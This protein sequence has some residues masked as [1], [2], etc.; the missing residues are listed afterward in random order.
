MSKL[1]LHW[2]IAIAIFLAIVVGALFDKQTAIGGISLYG[3][4]TFIGAM[5]LNGLK[6]VVV[7]LVLASIICAVAG[8]GSGAGLGRLGGKTLGFYMAS[9][10]LAIL[11]GLFFVN[12]M[13][14]GIVDGVPAKEILNLSSSDEL[15]AQLAKIEGRGAGDFAAV[16][17]R[18]LPPNIVEAAANG[19]M[20]G[21]ITF[22]LMFGFFMMRI[23]ESL[24]DT[25]QNFW[26]AVFETMMAI[27]MF[28]MKFAPIGVFG[29]I[30]KTI[31]ATGFSALE[32][33]A[34][35]ML[36]VVLAL[37]THTFITLPA[38][39]KFVARVSPIRHFQAMSPALLTAFSTASSSGTLPLTMKCVEKNAKVSNKTAGFVLP[40]GATVN[41]DGTAL[42]ECVA[43][44]FIAQAYGL[45]LSIATQFLIVITALLTSVGV[46][47][48]PSASLVAITVILAAIGLPAEGI[49]LLLLTDRILDMVRTSVNV[50]SDSVCAVVVAKTEGEQ[51]VL[52]EPINTAKIVQEA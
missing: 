23:K 39:L 18:M 29:L 52:A 12:V 7:P 31:L 37:A 21:L 26:Q 47:G 15:N 25:M 36:T 28:I 20:L 9:S 6:M 41:M 4:C 24:R 40:L 3:V 44:M 11:V 48:I 10:L 22:G 46:A 35:F 49:G 2:Q 34:W 45:E 30:A 17:L 16:F 5:F 8:L 32:P 1:A 13:T 19:Q 42:Y 27:T 14:P 33:L 43:A 51:G 38:A 50:F